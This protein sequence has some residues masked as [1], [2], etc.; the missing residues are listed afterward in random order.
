[1]LFDPPTCLPCM[2]E[3]RQ[4]DT[5]FSWQREGL[6]EEPKTLPAVLPS[7]LQTI[8]L[9]SNATLGYTLQELTVSRMKRDRKP[10]MLI[11]HV[12]TIQEEQKSQTD[13]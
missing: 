2:K 12:G 11:S 9:T 13:M 8:R 1:M 4:S 7:N 10:F 6:S 3:V 5:K